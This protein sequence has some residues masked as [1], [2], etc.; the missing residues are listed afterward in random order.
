ADIKALGREKTDLVFAP[1]VEDIYPKGFATRLVPEGPALAGLEDKFRPHFFSGVA[2]I[3]A[4]LLIEA[5][6]DIAIFG[7]KD[8]QQLLVIRRMARDLDLPVKIVGHHI[9]REK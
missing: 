8:Y 9:V 5:M 6:P 2:T 1:A 4:K 3:V 7:E